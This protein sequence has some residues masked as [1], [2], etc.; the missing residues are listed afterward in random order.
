[1]LT[2][3]WPKQH[4]VLCFSA[5]TAADV[6]CRDGLGPVD[7]IKLNTV[8][9]FHFVSSLTEL[10]QRLHCSSS[11]FPLPLVVPSC[12]CVSR[13]SW[14]GRRLQVLPSFAV[15][16]LLLIPPWCHVLPPEHATLGGRAWLASPPPR[17]ARTR[18]MGARKARSAC[19]RVKM[20][21]LQMNISRNLFF[22]GL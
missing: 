1:M 2:S 18:Q 9:L 3:F 4:L 7:P 21:Q 19:A 20:A 8:R 12:S 22:L 13:T 5:V 15:A 17:S 14:A 10:R 16:P 6:A 11:S